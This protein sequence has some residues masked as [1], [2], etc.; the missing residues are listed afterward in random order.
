MQ[1]RG[2]EVMVALNRL[3]PGSAYGHALDL[4]AHDSSGAKRGALELFANA[5]LD[6]VEIDSRFQAVVNTLVAEVV[7]SIFCFNSKTSF[8]NFAMFSTDDSYI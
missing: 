3:I 1:Q 2:I 6:G 5:V 4:L 8:S 7:F